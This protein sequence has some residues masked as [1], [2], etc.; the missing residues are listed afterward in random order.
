MTVLVT[1]LTK[2]NKKRIKKE[3][4]ERYNIE[5]HTIAQLY[6]VPSYATWQKGERISEMNL[7]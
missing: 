7:L 3:R 6:R 5:H 2:F 1:Y 4:N